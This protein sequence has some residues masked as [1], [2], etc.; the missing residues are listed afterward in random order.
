[1]RKKE[2]VEPSRECGSRGSEN[3]IGTGNHTSVVRTVVHDCIKEIGKKS[4]IASG[5]VHAIPK[6]RWRTATAATTAALEVG[7]I[8][9]MLTTTAVAR[10]RRR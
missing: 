9:G 8:E 4:T 5:R 1:V 6:T 7:T 10:M 3:T 2:E